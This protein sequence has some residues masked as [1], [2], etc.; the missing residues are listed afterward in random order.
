ME[1][2]FSIV[3]WVSLRGTCTLRV[4]KAVEVQGLQHE[5]GV[6]DLG[7]AGNIGVLKITYTILGGSL[8]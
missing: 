7:I 6:Q 2:I 1:V 4:Q 5:V 8:L 3:G